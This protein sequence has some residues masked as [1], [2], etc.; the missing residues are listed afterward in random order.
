MTK[1]APTS[2]ASCGKA[3]CE[4]KNLKEC[5]A[6]KLVK[7]CGEDCQNAHRPHHED[8]CKTRAA[9]LYDEALFRQP[10][11]EDDCPICFYMLPSRGSGRVSKACCGKIICAG[12]YHAHVLESN[13]SPTCP[14]CRADKPSGKETIE[15]LNKRVD[16]NDADAIYGLGCIYFNGSDYYDDYDIQ[17]DIDKAAKFFTVQLSLGV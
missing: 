10:A 8:A 16:A 11:K 15:M 14:F 13:G 7:Y 5:V 12:C 6:C 17:K 9:E 4:E 1:E 3:E 2:C